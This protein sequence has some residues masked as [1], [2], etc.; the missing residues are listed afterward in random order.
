M[1]RFRTDHI[2][3][4]NDQE[5]M[6]DFTNIEYLNHGNARQ[7]KAYKELTDLNIFEH[8]KKYYPLLTGTIPIEIDLPES[9]L[10]I[11]CEC[12][13]HD[14]FTETLTDLYSD[15]P[16]FDLRTSICGGLKST[17]ISFQSGEFDIEIFG[18]NCPTQ[19]QN[20]YQHMLIEYHILNSKDDTFRKQIIALKQEGLKTE[21]AFAQLLG[22]NGDPYEELLKFGNNLTKPQ[23]DFGQNNGMK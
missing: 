8:L 22:L 13:H 17:I 9:D 12:E 6:R 2:R 21:P 7:R 10:D 18:Q 4:E 14:E 19:S 11:I 20:A 23:L 3:S 1:N 16:N 5:Q 15:K